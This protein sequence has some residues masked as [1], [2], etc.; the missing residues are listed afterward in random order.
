M[1][2]AL[3]ASRSDEYA[4][5][6]RLF[7]DLFPERLSPSDTQA[8]SRS[9]QTFSCSI[10]FCYDLDFVIKSQNKSRNGDR[11]EPGRLPKLNSVKTEPAGKQTQK[12]ANLSCRLRNS[13]HSS[14]HVKVSLRFSL[15][16]WRET[17]CGF[18]GALSG[19]GSARP[20]DVIVMSSWQPKHGA[21]KT[22]TTSC[23]LKTWR[24]T[25]S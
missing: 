17:C 4:E 1:S 15:G 12:N 22:E 5:K 13:H 19:L 7:H 8:A 6:V 9:D 24:R 10:I 16:T 3:V 21:Q 20:A 18:T 2:I 14:S 23:K 25:D 11:L